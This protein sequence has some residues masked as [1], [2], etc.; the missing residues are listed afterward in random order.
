MYQS[1]T[2]QKLDKKLWGGASDFWRP[3][4]NFGGGQKNFRKNPIFG[5]FRSLDAVWDQLVF[6]DQ[7]IL[8]PKF[9]KLSKIFEKIWFFSLKSILLGPK[10][11]MDRFRGWL[12]L[13]NASLDNSGPFYSL[14]T[15]LYWN[16]S[17]FEAK[18]AS[19]MASGLV[20]LNMSSQDSTQLYFNI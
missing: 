7:K 8:R 18:M 16:F 12:Q 5:V 13:I 14:N 6:F 19:K 20:S 17:L 9:S 3:I 15:W 4:L 10:Y 11:V 2:H 1:T